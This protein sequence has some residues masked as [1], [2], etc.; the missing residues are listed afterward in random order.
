M[1][2]GYYNLPTSCYISF[3]Y[4]FLPIYLRSTPIDL[5]NITQT[6]KKQYWNMTT[7]MME[8][9]RQVEDLHIYWT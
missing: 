4:L 7:T 5:P 8:R 3:I 1:L 6:R 9:T 2:F